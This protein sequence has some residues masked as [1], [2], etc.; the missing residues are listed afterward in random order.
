M[1]ELAGPCDCRKPAPGMLL[2][3]AA[4]AAARP[5]EH[6]G[7]SATPMPTCS[8]GAGGGLP[9]DP[10]RAR[11]QRSQAS[12]AIDADA[13]VAILPTAPRCSRRTVR[14]IQRRRASLDCAEVSPCS[15]RSPHASS[16]TAPISTASSRS[17]AD[18]RISGFTTNPTLMWKAGLTDYAEF[19]QRLL[20]RITEHPISFEVFA[21]DAEEMRRQALA[22]RLAGARTSTSRSPSRP[23]PASRWRRSS[24]ELSEEGVKVNVTALFTHRPGGADHSRRQGR[25]AVVYLGVRRTH[26]RRRRSIPCRSWPARW[27]S[28]ST[29]RARS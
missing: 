2:D 4:R 7:W 16:P 9:H 6:R 11:R 20:E 5:R 17:R 23:P 8:P 27:R 28:W 13:V 18:P 29:R 21:D 14:D 25:R 1:P 22:D 10:D 12:R 26:R 24:R 19:A 3:A 15:T